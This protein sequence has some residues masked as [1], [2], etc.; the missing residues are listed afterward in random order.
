MVVE[1]EEETK[2]ENI[3]D[4]EENVQGEIERVVNQRVENTTENSSY[5]KPS[6]VPEV[7]EEWPTKIWDEVRQA[8]NGSDTWKEASIEELDLDNNC[9]DL[10]QQSMYGDQGTEQTKGSMDETLKELPSFLGPYEAGSEVVYL[11]SQT[12]NHTPV[13]DT[14]TLQNLLSTPIK[15]SVTMPR[16]NGNKRS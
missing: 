11:S 12:R 7:N 1:K 8:K 6:A 2:Q 10:D 16:K 4:A 15:C 5:S 3:Q 13:L 14:P 9:F